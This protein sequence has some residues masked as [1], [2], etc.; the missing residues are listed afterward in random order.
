M[1]RPM[2]RNVENPM[3]LCHAGYSES[4]EEYKILDDLGVQALRVDF[5]WGEFQQGPNQ[6]NLSA[7]DKYVDTAIQHGKRVIAI[8][9]SDNGAVEQDPVGKNRGNYIAPADLPA[10]LNF[11]HQVVAHY[12]GRVYAWEIWN[13]PDL[14]NFWDGPYADFYPLARQNGGGYPCR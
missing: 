7:K 8:L 6:W 13:E 12:K 4:D 1:N 9:N 11:V 14:P 3:G 10:F 5:R 2:V